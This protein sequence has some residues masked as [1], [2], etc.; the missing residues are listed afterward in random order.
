MTFYGNINL[1][2]TFTISESGYELD[3]KKVFKICYFE[4]ELFSLLISKEKN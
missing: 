1:Y 4:S 2:D 3:S